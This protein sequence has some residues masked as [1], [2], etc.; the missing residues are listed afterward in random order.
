MPPINVI[1]NVRGKKYEI[2]AE[3]VEE[4]SLKVEELSGLEADQQSVLFKGKVLDDTA[5]FDE[6]G[7]I[8]GDIL[9]VLK[10]RKARA[11]KA[12]NQLPSDISSVSALA[13]SLDSDSNY[14]DK[15]NNNNIN[16]DINNPNIN[17]EDALKNMNPEDIKAAMQ[18]MDKML[19][20]NIIEDYFSDEQK[21]E[22]ARLEM[23]NNLDQYEQMM[24]GFK[25]QAREIASDPVKWREAMSSARDQIIKM[26][27]Q[28]DAMRRGSSGID[29]GSI[30]SGSSSK[31][32]ESESSN[33]YSNDEGNESSVDDMGEED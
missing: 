31:S 20:S 11:S 13:S 25:E 3:N 9:N 8:S 4:F 15:N 17:P 30:G 18:S 26:K 27:A 28:R 1:A 16:F 2:I 32:L 5:K 6:V 14:D 33:S 22:K 21:L 7:I 24:P 19:D 12:F 10:G 23:L 29:D